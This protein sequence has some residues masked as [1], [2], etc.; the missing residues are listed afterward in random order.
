MMRARRT[1]YRSHWNGDRVYSSRSDLE[2][3]QLFVQ[4]TFLLRDRSLLR[5]EVLDL[6]LEVEVR[7]RLRVLAVIRR[8]SC[9]W[10]GRVVEGSG[11]K[12]DHNGIVVEDGV[13]VRGNGRGVARK[14]RRGGGQRHINARIGSRK[15]D[16]DLSIVGLINQNEHRSSAGYSLML[17]DQNDYSPARRP[18]D[19]RH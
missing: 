5:L 1:C 13:R 16:G 14:A 15:L 7:D 6:G 9:D 19:P 10:D 17:L 2:A 8:K 18:L 3:F 4:L 11:R 12:L